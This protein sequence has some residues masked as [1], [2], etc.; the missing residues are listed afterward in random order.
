MFEASLPYLF[1]DTPYSRRT[2]IGSYE[3]LKTFKHESLTD[4]YRKWYNPDMQAVIVVGDVDVNAVEAKIKEMFSDIP[5]P[6]VPTV[7]VPVKIADN[8]EPIVGVITDPEATSSYFE[9][10]WKS[11]PMPEMFNS[12]LEGK[13]IT[14]VKRYIQ[15]I[16]GERFNDI[17]SKPDAPFLGAGI[18]FYPLCEECD[19]LRGQVTFK[20]GDA[21]N[22][23]QVNWIQA[24]DNALSQMTAVKTEF[25][26]HIHNW[27]VSLFPGKLK[28]LAER[29][30]E[31]YRFYL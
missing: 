10:I 5:A 7:K 22:A 8:Q 4:F 2:L 31:L 29:Y 6:A 27:Q 13:M 11:Q 19:A 20:D 9:L 28:P 26:A 21:A 24:L 25:Y 17:A 12:T 1:G 14:I 3:Q 15:M 18:Y 16:M 30:L 23:L